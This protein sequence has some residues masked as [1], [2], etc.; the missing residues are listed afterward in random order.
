MKIFNLILNFIL[1]IIKNNETKFLSEF[2]KFFIRFI[3][4]IILFC[5][6]FLY[7]GF[8]LADSNSF[9]SIFYL[10]STII[11]IFFFILHL[12]FELPK[13]FVYKYF[14]YYMNG[15]YHAKVLKIGFLFFP[16]L[17]NVSEKRIG[18]SG[19]LKEITYCAEELA[20]NAI[21]NHKNNLKE[22]RNK[23]FE[24]KKL[25]EIENIK[26]IKI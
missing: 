1:I 10:L 26:I 24:R 7:L 17:C 22:K 25:S 13:I 4:C 14:I 12:N 11:L 2:Y 3:F 16:H 19:S 23:F 18:F 20:R 6:R 15:E 8:G 21:Y 9:L 5:H